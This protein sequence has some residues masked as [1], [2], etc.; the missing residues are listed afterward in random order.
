MTYC[1]TLADPIKQ[2]VE[3]E[4]KNLDQ[5]AQE[6]CGSTVKQGRRKVIRIIKE[7][8]GEKYLINHADILGYNPSKAVRKKGTSGKLK[9][10]IVSEGQQTDKSDSNF[11]NILEKLRQLI[12]ISSIE[13]VKRAILLI[14]QGSSKCQ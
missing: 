7:L 2:K 9:Q 8:L 14:E 1:S 5:I 13:E 6:L 4:N 10:K 12:A 3:G 11:D